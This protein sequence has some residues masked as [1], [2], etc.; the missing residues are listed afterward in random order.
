MSAETPAFI[1]VSDFDGTAAE[2]DVQ[3]VILDALADPQAWRAINRAWAEGKL[4]TA[5]RARQ[6]WALI[7]ASEA[8]VLRVLE[9]LRLDP[10]F[11]AFARFCAARGYPLHI[12]SDGFDLYI[13][14]I[15][16]AAGLGH[17]PVVANGLRYVDDAPEFRFL[18]QRSPDQFYAN[19]KTFVIE[20]LRRPGS[21]VVFAGDGNSDRDAAHVADLL[22]AKEALA[23]Y[24]REQ[25]LQFVPFSTFADVQ[26]EL[27]ARASSA[28]REE[29]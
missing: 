9:P 2:R 21:T 3:Q 14:P 16:R 22:F 29:I 20:Q 12:V 18:L 1:V 4:T 17:L 26:R 23:T 27:E 24:C 7:D 25:G 13:D 11:P 28:V 15:L 8:E 10:G 5:Q 19:D 6:Q